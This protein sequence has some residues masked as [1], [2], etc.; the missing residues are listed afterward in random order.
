M[1]QA[2]ATVEIERVPRLASSSQMKQSKQEPKSAP[3]PPETTVKL[4]QVAMMYPKKT[5]AWTSDHHRHGVGRE[6]ADRC[7]STGDALQGRCASCDLAM[8]CNALFEP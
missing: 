8:S 4:M 1:S 2:A 7:A 3:N 6:A 5:V